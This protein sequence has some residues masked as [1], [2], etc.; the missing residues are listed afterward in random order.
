MEENLSLVNPLASA[1]ND[2]RLLA[3]SFFPSFLNM[4]LLQFS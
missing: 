2:D 3:N 1:S 4:F